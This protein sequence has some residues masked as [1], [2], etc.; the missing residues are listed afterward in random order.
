MTSF[1]VAIKPIPSVKGHR[2]MLCKCRCGALKPVRA[3]RLRASAVLSCGCRRHALKTHCKWGH[4]Y[5]G[6]NVGVGLK[7]GR[8][9]CRACVRSTGKKRWVSQRLQQA[10]CRSGKTSDRLYLASSA[11]LHKI[12]VAVDV[13][14]RIRNLHNASAVPVRLIATG[15]ACCPFHTRLLEIYLHRLFR[16]HSHHGEWFQLP[17]A[18]VRD[19]A[20]WLRML[21][22]SNAAVGVLLQTMSTHA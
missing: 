15:R 8:R 20:C 4:P 14:N 9:F 22:G 6:G 18:K 7:G 10:C 16:N 2:M 1:L 11:R 17:A 3:S 5:S 21:D 19:V 13:R 12:G